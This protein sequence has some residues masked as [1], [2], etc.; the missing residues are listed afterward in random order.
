[1][2]S[3]SRY[4]RGESP[5]GEVVVP[6]QQPEQQHYSNE[7]QSSD[8]VEF[9][10]SDRYAMAIRRRGGSGLLNLTVASDRPSH[11]SDHELRS[12]GVYLTLT[13]N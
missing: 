4:I 10:Q 8:V 2:A 5:S 13:N 3:S 12:A 6:K 11:P 9:E 7:F 1:M